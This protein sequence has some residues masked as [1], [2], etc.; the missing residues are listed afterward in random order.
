MCWLPLPAA[1][2]FA[3]ALGSLA[4]IAYRPL[5]VAAAIGTVLHFAG[6]VAVAAS[7]SDA[8]TAIIDAI[9]SK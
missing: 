1:A 7:R 9:D 6:A 3:G 4:G 8:T 5:G 2:K